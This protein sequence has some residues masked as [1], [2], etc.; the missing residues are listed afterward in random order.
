[1]R[2]TDAEITRLAEFKGLSEFDFIQEFTR[3]RQDKQGL[4]LKD[5]PNGECIF[6]AGN[7]CSVQP[8]K[9]QQCQ[10]FPNLWN[11]PGFEKICHAIPKLVSEEEYVRL[12]ERAT[13]V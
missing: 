11:F 4:A 10:D 8:V 1:M 9:P 13:K 7:D 3:L 5:K 12:I 6:L 2:L